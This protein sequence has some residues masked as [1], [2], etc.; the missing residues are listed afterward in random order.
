MLLHL[1]FLRLCAPCLLLGAIGV[2]MLTGCGRQLDQGPVANVVAAKNIRSV[3]VTAE[4]L[5][6][7]GE[8]AAAAGGSGWATIRGQFVYGGDPTAIQLREL[9]EVLNHDDRAVCAP[10]GKPPRSEALVVDSATRGIKNVAIYLRSASRVHESAATP[11]S[12]PILFDQQHCVFLTRVFG[13]TIGQKVEVKNSDPT[14]HNTKV[15]GKNSFN[16]TIP[17]GESIMYE[18]QKEEAL[19]TPI[20]CSIHPWMIAY[21]LPRQNGYYAVTDEQ[22]QFEIANVPAGEEL[23]FQVWHESGAASGN[24]LVGQSDDAELKWDNRGRVKVT[25]EPD[26]VREVKITVPPTAFRG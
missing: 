20:T 21:M 11:P 10:G 13:V 26:E 2:L 14:G 22:G 17:R 5:T 16:Q 9:T 12:E 23:E 7:S 1:V 15:G 8:V 3:L 19:P 6:E 4:E 24:G 18:P 25:L